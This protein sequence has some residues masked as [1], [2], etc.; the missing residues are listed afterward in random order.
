MEARIETLAEATES[1]G[2][3]QGVLLLLTL[4][5][6]HHLPDVLTALQSAPY[7]VLR[8]PPGAGKT[9]RVPPALLD[10]PWCRNRQVWVLQP[11]RVAAR[12][13][14]ARMAEERAVR[15]GEE[16]GYQVRFERRC[17][18]RTRLLVM[19]EGVLMRRLLDDPFLQD[20]AVVVLDEFHERHL[21]TDVSLAMLRRVQ[22]TV[23]PDLKLIVMSA[24]LSTSELQNYLPDVPVITCE[25]RTH[26][27]E[28]E[29]LPS[30]DLRPLPVQVE[31]AVRRL[32]TETP[33]DV[34]AFLPGVREIQ[35]TA[36]R[37]A[38]VPAEVLP[39]YG[40]LPVEQQ[41]RVF[42]PCSRQKVVLATNVA[43]TSI[44][45]PGVTAVVDSGLARIAEL[46]P[47]LGW[48]RLALRPISQ[49][50]ADQRAGRAGRT[51][52]GRCLRLWPL[53]AH[54]TRPAYELP[55]IHRVDLAGVVL[56]LRCWGETDLRH[57]P[58][59][60]PPRPE[61]LERAERLLAALDAVTETGPTTS[62]R[63]LAALPV[64][65]RLGRLL[66]EGAQQGHAWEAA[67]AAAWLSERDPFVRSEPAGAAGS[68]SPSDILDR[69]EALREFCRSG[70]THHPPVT[71][72]PASAQRIRQAAE[73]LMAWLMPL[74]AASQSCVSWEEALG[75][76]LLAAFPDRVA[77]RRAPRSRKALLVGG[78]G[79]RLAD[80]S[81]VIEPELF[82]A[83]DVDAGAE[84]VLV[85][86]AS[87]IERSWL[88]S[89]HLHT[90][91]E[92]EYDAEQDRVQARQRTRWFDLMVEESPAELPDESLVAEVL[93]Q[94]ARQH[95][96][97]VFPPEDKAAIQLIM[98]V[99]CLQQWMPE[100]NLPVWD[101]ATLQARVV[102]LCWGCRSLDEVRHGPW[103]DVLWRSLTESQRE[104]L[105][106]EAPARIEVPSGSR[107]P[108]QYEP[109]R[110]PVLA[111][112]IQEIFG[113]QDTPRIAG[114]RVRVLLHLLAPNHRPQQITDDLP[115]FWSR[116]YPLVRG[117]L[118][119]RYPKHA[120]PEDPRTAPAER[121]PQR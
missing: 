71:L 65:P 72:Q 49:A 53:A 47:A 5:I 60:D 56:Q 80:S 86:L 37:L 67:L 22:Q 70:R 43:E 120:W 50:A 21:E 48:N 63:Q 35:Q 90:Q 92:V 38:D 106:R 112:R 16:I 61:A 41:Q 32:L 27:V 29:Y 83:V 96:S 64:H 58:W 78:R 107:V 42:A 15:L 19:T 95:W 9:T 102:E 55:E 18:A 14:A 87:G 33:G 114:G 88:P 101:E 66:W 104:L 12:T 28:I 85:R 74:P 31:L 30:V 62:G 109:G 20:V 11:R 110:P 10:A 2:L 76:A 105:E 94:A 100:A 17:S 45:I 99:Q 73:Q 111:V 23:R 93:A 7:V 59:F 116:G 77:R 118:R 52:P 117:E 36:E 8:A 57:F 97:R 25:A 3:S 54:R 44:T 113:W 84:E 115:S 4:P 39:L 6:D 75:R 89:T 68:A 82:L 91:T 1:L 13:T 79:A 103:H 34:L 51:G 24:T 69:V 40:D 46:D 26:P 108:V 81:A 119:R 121:R 98:R